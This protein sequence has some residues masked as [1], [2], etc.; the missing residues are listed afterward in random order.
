VA[1]SKT[2]GSIDVL[3]GD[4]VMRLQQVQ[5]EDG[6]PVMPST[7]VTS[8][9]T[10]LGLSTSEMLARLQALERQ[11]AELSR[12]LKELTHTARV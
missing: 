7:L 9:R 2:E 12:A 5:L 1:V 4:G 10:T 3:T 6:A 8:V 11:V